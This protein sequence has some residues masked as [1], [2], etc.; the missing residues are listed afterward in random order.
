MKGR[1]KFRVVANRKGELEVQYVPQKVREA[2]R[3][4]RKLHTVKVCTPATK[5]GLGS[6]TGGTVPGSEN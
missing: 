1:L 5:N 3:E 2:I 4:Q 6:A